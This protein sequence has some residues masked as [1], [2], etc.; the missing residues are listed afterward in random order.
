MAIDSIDFHKKILIHVTRVSKCV[1]VVNLSQ[2]AELCSKNDSLQFLLSFVLSG[3]FKEGV[4]KIHP[5]HCCSAINDI[6]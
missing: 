5:G 2:S 1:L 6:F 3:S 4:R